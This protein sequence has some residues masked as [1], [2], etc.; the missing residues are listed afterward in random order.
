MDKIVIIDAKR[1]A[2]GKLNGTLSSLTA[3]QLGTSVTSALLK[4]TAIRPDQI[5]HVIFGNAIQAG[6]GQ[7]IARQIELNSGIPEN[8]TAYTVNQVC[9]SGLQAI[10]QAY[11][12]LLLG[13]TTTV[14]A[15]GT[16]S[17]SNVPYLNMSQRKATKFGPVTLYDGL[18]RDGLTDSSTDQPM[19]MTAENVADEYHVSRHEQDLFALRSHQRAAAAMKQNYFAD[20]IIPLTIPQ[21]KSKAP[22][23]ITTD[24][25]V[26]FDTNMEKLANLRPAFKADGTVTAGNSAPLSDGA[27]ALLL[28]TATHADSLDVKPVAEIL[29]YAECGI[30]P[31]VMGYAP[32]LAINKLLQKL[33]MATD[34]IDLFEI[35]EAFASQSVAVIRDL[36]ISLEKVNINGGAIALGHPLGD[37]GARIVTT[38]IHN[39]KRTHQ[40]FGIAAL[41][42]GGGMGSALAVKLI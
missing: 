33:E 26:R 6:N 38:L 34:D 40:E 35:N 32:Y 20:E 36:D 37:S 23:T 11:T 15:G 5:D 28:T 27:S 19:G 14:I 42:M 31:N 25:S 22:L 4:S 16:E 12:S 1:T 9:G 24:E 30:D 2:I 39:L 13:E 29:G 17:M 3:E 18:Q 8:K 7:N 41:C 21:P 10:H